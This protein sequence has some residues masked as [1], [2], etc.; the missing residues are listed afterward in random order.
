MQPGETDETL[1]ALLEQSLARLPEERSALRSRLLARLARELH[2]SPDVAR[3]RALAAEAV[4]I[5]EKAGDP[6]THAF[7]LGA[8]HVAMGSPDMVEERLAATATQIELAQRAGDVELELWGRV[9]RAIDLLELGRPDASAEELDECDVLAARLRQPAQTWRVLLV[10]GTLALL[11]GRFDEAE[12]LIAQAYDTG[13][14]AR[15]RAAHRYRLLQESELRFLRGG[16]AELEPELRALAAEAPAVWGG[17]LT[18]MLAITGRLDEARPGFELLAASDFGGPVDDLAALPR[19]SRCAEICRALGDEERAAV[20]Y[21]RL[22]PHADRWLV[23]A[24]GLCTGTVRVRLGILAAT[25]GRLED[26]AAHF[27][28]AVRAHRAAGAAPITALAEF[29]L[30]EILRK[31]GREERADE[32][33]GHALRTA[34]ALGMPPLIE[35][36]EGAAVAAP[37]TPAD[38]ARLALEGE[39]W[40]AEFRGAEVRVRDRKGIAH[41]ARLVE[42]PHRELSALELSG[43]AAPGGDAG[44]LLDPEA[45]RAYRTRVEELRR[46][47]DEAG[48]WNDPERAERASAELAF[49][50]AE[51]SRAVGLGGRDRRA[52]SDAE[53][54]RVSVTRT[55]RTAIA[56]ITE[57]HPQLGRHLDTA[58]RTGT[59]CR[60][61]PGPGDEV[62]WTVR[63][64]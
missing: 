26:A 1:V 8:W 21:E 54:A 23:F 7:A 28:A 20:L 3:P 47:V 51:L 35:R 38:R 52:A 50:T 10:R 39:Y 55:L 13:R 43:A 59:H 58:V 36:I 53:R 56:S 40:V 30:A 15:G 32:L 4:A 5:A 11:A 41:L 16:P 57:Q 27:E 33:T 9:L 31:L 62:A 37:A 25:M 61:A 60:Y 64:G 46:E 44:E 17:T 2:F 12:R 14:V 63:R 29:E 6:A 42:H 34:R 24:G 45:K 49:V 22:T 19:L 18:H 48:R